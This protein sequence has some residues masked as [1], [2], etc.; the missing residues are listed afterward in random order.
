M[1][2]K[3]VKFVYPVGATPLDEDEL[4]ALIPEHVTTQ[5]QLDELELINIARS[6]S[7]ASETS[8]KVVADEAFLRRLHKKMLGDV[9]YW[10][11]TF[12]KTEKTIG[13]APEQ[14]AIRARDLCEDVRTWIE[15]ST[16]SADEIPA[17]FITVLCISTH[18]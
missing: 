5:A 2:Q 14:I 6:D 15:Y 7:G 17:R 13:V 1:G 8:I 3:I 18:L 4:S 11:G 12:R 16:Y 9:W 10:A